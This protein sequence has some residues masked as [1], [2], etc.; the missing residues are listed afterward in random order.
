MTGRHLEKLKTVKLS[1]LYVIGRNR[2]LLFLAV[3][4]ASLLIAGGS[5]AA[6]SVGGTSAHSSSHVGKRLATS[7]TS[8][9]VPANEVDAPTVAIPGGASIGDGNFNA[10]TCT[11]STNCVAV[12]GDNNLD[13]VV[14]TSSD[15]GSR[16]SQGT[17]S[18]GEPELNAVTCQSSR[19]CVAVGQGATVTSSDGGS[20]WTTHA[21][22]TPNTTLLGVSCPSAST[23][24]SVGVSPGNDGPYGGQLLF[25]SDSGV[26]WNVPTLPKDV[27]ALG[28]VDCPSSSFCV[29]VGAQILVSND[30]GQSWSQ[31]FVDGGTGVL[32]S[33]SCSSASDCVAIGAN[34]LGATAP[35]SAAFE[36]VTTDGGTTWNS[37]AT[38]AGSWTLNAI[39]CSNGVDCTVGGLS[40]DSDPAPAWSSAD[41]GMTWSSVNLPSGVSAISSIT[42]QSASTC[43]LVVSESDGSPVVV[44]HFGGGG[45]ADRGEWYL[46]G[47][48]FDLGRGVGRI[49]TA[50][51]QRRDDEFRCYDQHQLHLR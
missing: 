13:G 12:G 51:H 14:A 26:T 22:P 39:S 48:R 7:V 20:T 30:G 33:V 8:W 18:L 29:A 16:W 25:S 35:A 47:D 38:P 36:V 15:G 37:V 50:Q 11:T 19:D 45:G 3:V 43:V 28:S 5:I 32:R 10:A 46:V 23:C 41:G 49:D 9:A 1:M 24:V 4:G 44:G 34:P 2:R 42:C 17:V 21:I 6:A 40:F 27:G 31:Q